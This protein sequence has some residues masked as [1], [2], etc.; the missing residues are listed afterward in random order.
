MSLEKELRIKLG[1]TDSDFAYH[2][3]DLYVRDTPEVRAYLKKNY[4]FWRNVKGFTCQIEGVLWFDIPFA[5]E[6]FWKDRGV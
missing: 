3:S 4:K 2:E 6:K 1:L 5:N